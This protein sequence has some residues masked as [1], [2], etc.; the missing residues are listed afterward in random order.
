M[1]AAEAVLVELRAQN[2]QLL[3]INNVLAAGQEE[4]SKE[5]KAV[6]FLRCGATFGMWKCA[7]ILILSPRQYTV[8][9][10]ARI[11]THLCLAY[12]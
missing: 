11:C 4:L 5:L 7:V 6:D 1:S 2:Q 12:S 9:C 3:G 10:V 8:F